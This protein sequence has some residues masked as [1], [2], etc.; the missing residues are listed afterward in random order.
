MQS[1]D[2]VV[3]ATIDG[4]PVDATSLTA[5]ELSDKCAATAGPVQLAVLQAT[6]TTMGKHAI[7]WPVGRPF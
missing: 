2:A 5:G 3:Q 7:T 1:H 6:L 4:V